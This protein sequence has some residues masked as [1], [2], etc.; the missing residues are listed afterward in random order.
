MF[1]LFSSTTNARELRGSQ[2]FNNETSIE[3]HERP[4]LRERTRIYRE[5]IHHNETHE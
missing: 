5:S 3:V 4:T 2:L 1:R